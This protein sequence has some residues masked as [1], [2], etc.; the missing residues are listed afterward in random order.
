MANIFLDMP[1]ACDTSTPAFRY[2][3]D[4]DSISIAIM[5]LIAPAAYSTSTLAVEI[6]KRLRQYLNGWYVSKYTR[7][8]IQ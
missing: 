1:A 4:V 6:R 5:F 8:R 7:S 2:K 3:G